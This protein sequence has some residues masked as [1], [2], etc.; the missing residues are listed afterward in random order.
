MNDGKGNFSRSRDA[1]PEMHTSKGC[2]AVSDVNADG[3]AD[4][5]IGGRVIP[6]RYPEA[7]QSY[8]LMNDGSNIPVSTRKRPEVIKMLEE[9]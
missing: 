9:L 7:P 8:L 6:G 2:V 1:L 5:F 3:F 4:L